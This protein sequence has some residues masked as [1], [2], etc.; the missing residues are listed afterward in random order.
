MAGIRLDYAN[1]LAER[2]GDNGLRAEE[3][4]RAQGGL[5]ELTEQLN[6]TMGSGWQRWRSL[7]FD[8]MRSEHVTAVRRLTDELHSRIDNLVVL[9]IGGSALGNIALHGALRPSTWNLLPREQRGG[10]QSWFHEMTFLGGS[11]P[12]RRNG[13]PFVIHAGAG[14][15]MR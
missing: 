1:C 12:F 4:E 5:T 10:P 14:R 15:P 2:V 13:T 9:G 8:P 11:F 6:Q 7:P 3:L